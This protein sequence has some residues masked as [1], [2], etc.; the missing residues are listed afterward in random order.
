M[1]ILLRFSKLRTVCFI[2]NEN[3]LFLIYCQ[4]IFT[5]QK[6]IQFLNRGYDDLIIIL[7]NISL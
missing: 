3:H 1:E 6:V 2:K 4:I 5:F 7:F